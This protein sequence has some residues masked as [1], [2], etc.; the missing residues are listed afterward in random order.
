MYAYAHTRAHVH[1]HM[2]TQTMRTRAYTHKHTH[3]TFETDW[4]QNV[5]SNVNMA[6]KQIAGLILFNQTVSATH[7]Y[8]TIQAQVFKVCL[9]VYVKCDSLC[10]FVQLG[11]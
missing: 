5:H 9:R 1:T 2:N 11:E 10:V 3:T 4:W 6:M 7:T 8:A